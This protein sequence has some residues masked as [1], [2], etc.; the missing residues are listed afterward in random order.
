M[1]RIRTKWVCGFGPSSWAISI[2]GFSYHGYSHVAPML[3]DGSHIDARNDWIKLKD[4]TWIPPGVQHRPP[5]YEKWKRWAIVEFEVTE[6]QEF[7][8]YAFLHQQVVDKVQY[9]SRAILGIIF[10]LPLH[11][12][13][14][15][16]CS[17]MF[18]AVMHKIGVAKPTTVKGYEVSPDDAYLLATAGWGGTVTRKYG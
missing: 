14:H 10:G 12:K 13:G 17:E 11:A 8:Y 5:N 18:F 7:Q 3:A 16:M 4:G 1:A 2:D 9:D 15:Y 6:E